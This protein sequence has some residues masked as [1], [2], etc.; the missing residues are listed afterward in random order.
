MG[1]ILEEIPS[2]KFIV[3]LRN[4]MEMAV[5]L[6]AQALSNKSAAYENT[7]S[8][9]KAWSY[10]DRRFNGERIGLR[11]PKFDTRVL[12][13][14]QACFLGTQLKVLLNQVPRNQLHIIVM[15]DLKA[16][17]RSEWLKLQDFLGLQDDQRYDFN[18][19]NSVYG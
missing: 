8:F 10:S 4:P 15:D 6:H 17:P 7:Q 18:V 13:Y 11:G 5:S 14:K 9:A 2:A 3:C 19:F 16:D 12:S 1:E